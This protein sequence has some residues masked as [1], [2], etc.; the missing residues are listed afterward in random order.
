MVQIETFRPGEATLIQRHSLTRDY[1]VTD[2][3]TEK[4]AFQY[5][6]RI[7]Y[8]LP[9]TI[10]RSALA[11][12]L[13]AASQAIIYK[14]VSHEPILS[15]ANKRHI[16]L[17]ADCIGLIAGRQRIEDYIDEFGM[18]VYVVSR[19]SYDIGQCDIDLRMEGVAGE[20]EVQTFNKLEYDLRS[21][22]GAA[23]HLV[24]VRDVRAVPEVGGTSVMV[25]TRR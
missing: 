12:I 7:R 1:V 13:K 9:P 19:L 20:V 16:Q 3:C 15:E 24:S 4:G 18:N 6:R 25:G 23:E 11:A 2:W 5:D 10:S 14:I 22:T 8:C 17:Q 21:R